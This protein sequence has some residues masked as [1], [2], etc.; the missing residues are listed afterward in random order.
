[1]EHDPK[2]ALRLIY[3]QARTRLY[4]RS[5]RA[6]LNR[7]AQDV[8]RAKQTDTV[9]DILRRAERPSEQP[10]DDDVEREMARMLARYQE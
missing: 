2:A 3:E 1:M 10:N 5:H 9:A 6:W 8:A 7:I 4:V